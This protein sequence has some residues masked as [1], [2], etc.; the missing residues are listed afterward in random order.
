LGF[1]IRDPVGRICRESDV[2]AVWL[3]K[4][5]FSPVYVDVPSGG[6]PESWRR[7]E[8]RQIWEGIRDMAHDAG[9]LA[10]VHLT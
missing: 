1:E 2:G 10:L 8:L 5:L 7:E 4:L 9:K 6:S 3:R